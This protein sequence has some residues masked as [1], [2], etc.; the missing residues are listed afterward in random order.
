MKALKIRPF[1]LP[2]FIR[3]KIGSNLR[4]RYT[5]INEYKRNLLDALY[6]HVI[7]CFPARFGQNRP[8]RPIMTL[9]ELWCYR[10]I[11]RASN[12]GGR[13]SAVKKMAGS[14]FLGCREKVN[15][16]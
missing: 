5:D 16:S 6:W 13:G 4:F 15:C 10:L 2:S 11:C 9:T 14:V 8:T 7:K 12:S 3:D 1:S